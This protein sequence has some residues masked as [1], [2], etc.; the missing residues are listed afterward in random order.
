ML[1][2]KRNIPSLISFLNPKSSEEISTLKYFNFVWFHEFFPIYRRKRNVVPNH[3]IPTDVP[4]KKHPNGQYA[5]NE[6]ST[7]QY[8]WWNFLFKN[9]YQQF[10]RFANIY[11]LFIICLNFIPETEA[12]GKEIAM[13]VVYLW[14]IAGRSRGKAFTSLQQYHLETITTIS[15]ARHS[16]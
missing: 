8:T 4:R 2:G 9:L 13:W 6:I 12:I 14:F 3:T 7:T 5:T 16:S 15:P 10:K 1:A 11:F